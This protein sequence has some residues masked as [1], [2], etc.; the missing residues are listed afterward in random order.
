[1]K[2]AAVEASKIVTFIESQLKLILGKKV[3][4]NCKL[5]LG[6]C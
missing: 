4:H 5:N 3:A 1:M 6:K 2:M